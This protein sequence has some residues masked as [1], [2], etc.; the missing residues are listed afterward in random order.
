MVGSNSD[1]LF[2]NVLFFKILN[3]SSIAGCTNAKRNASSICLVIMRK[4]NDNGLLY[5]TRSL[6]NPLPV[7]GNDCLNSLL[8]S[9]SFAFISVSLT[10]KGSVLAGTYPPLYEPYLLTIG[11]ASTSLK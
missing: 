11:V 10:K 4:S 6:V 8:K 2:A 1:N 3:V 5:S 7:E 9:S